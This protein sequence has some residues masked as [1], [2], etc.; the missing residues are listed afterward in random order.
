[1]A[2]RLKKESL[3]AFIVIV[4]TLILPL[5]I[6]ANISFYGCFIPYLSYAYLP[7]CPPHK[8]YLSIT[9]IQQTPN[10]LQVITN[11]F[12]DD[13]EI[14]LSDFYQKKIFITDPD[15][16]TYT[17]NYFKEYFLLYQNEKKLLFEWIGME[18]TVDKAEIYFEYPKITSIK[19]LSLNNRILFRK[20]PEQKNMTHL[21]TLDKQRFSILHKR[22]DNIK[23]WN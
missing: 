5:N 15:I 20:F 4:Y 23:K 1:M 14:E 18:I 22:E 9:Q 13:L 11:V 2:F 3:F 10:S 21:I 8:F 16:S 19:N 17:K 12:W 7:V 6:Q